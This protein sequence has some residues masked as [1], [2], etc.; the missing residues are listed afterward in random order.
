MSECSVCGQTLSM[1]YTCSECGEQHC[2]EHQLP[3]NH[4][5][6]A[7]ITTVR[8]GDDGS[9]SATRGQ[10]WT[11]PS[12]SNRPTHPGDSTNRSKTNS[13]SGLRGLLSRRAV[14]VL[15][16]LLVVVGAA[17][18][19]FAPGSPLNGATPSLEGAVDAAGSALATGPDQSALEQAVHREVNEARSN[20]SL[21]TVA[22]SDQLATAARQ[23]SQ[24]MS[25]HAFVDHYS[26]RN[27]SPEARYQRAGVCYGGENLWKFHYEG[28]AFSEQDLAEMAVQDWLDSPGHR[29]NLLSSRWTREGIGVAVNRS[30]GTTVYITQT[31]C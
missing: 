25:A 27:G 3:E 20:R 14:V 19:A 24:D 18:A 1:P 29:Q 10:N 12:T 11:P 21:S 28:L 13:K 31:F 4:D 7:L 5:C 6:E 22:W 17:A 8:F 30:D 9:V 23:H 2:S 26:P 15:I 16:G